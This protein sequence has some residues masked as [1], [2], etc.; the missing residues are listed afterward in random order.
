[1]ARLHLETTA[2]AYAQAAVI[3]AE[4][5]VI[6]DAGGVRPLFGRGALVIGEIGT[7]H[8]GQLA[9]GA[10]HYT[11]KQEDIRL[12][13]SSGDPQRR[14]AYGFYA[15]FDHPVWGNDERGVNLFARAG[16][17]D[18]V[19]TPYT[20]GWQ[21]GLLARGLIKGRPDSQLSLGMNQAFVS[22]R[23][24]QNAA[25]LGQTMRR[26]ETAAELTFVDKPVSWLT[27]QP[28]FQYIWNAQNGPNTGH[29]MVVTVRLRFSFAS[30]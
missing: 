2:G 22:G 27:V 15:L 10:W 21:A 25:D 5:G 23:H 20:G 8:R 19:T 28:D 26:R 4:A 29:A 11:A 6:G 17:S 7:R 24:R 30:E 1:M 18:G 12:L 3:N 9:L 13:S 16:I 14:Q